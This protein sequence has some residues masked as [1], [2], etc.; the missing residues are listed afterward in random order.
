L[1]GRPFAIA[2]LWRAW[3]DPDGASLSFT[4]LPVN[5]DGHPLMKRFLRPGDE[6]RSLV[7][8]R[9]EECD[10]WLGARSTDGARSF[11]NLLPAE[12][13]FAEAAPKAAK[14]PAP[15]LDDDAQASLL[16]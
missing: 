4:M 9:P 6:K 12:E 13:M 7:I 16:G 2:G 15:K 8:L 14:N 3:E 5:A 1:G 10:D 11:V